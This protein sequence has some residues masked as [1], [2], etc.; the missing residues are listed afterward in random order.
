MIKK[1]NIVLGVIIMS[2]IFCNCKKTKVNN[3][4]L[5][6]TFDNERIEQDAD[7]VIDEN[8]ER[9]YFLCPDWIDYLENGYMDHLYSFEIFNSKDIVKS[10][11][12]YK[13]KGEDKK[14]FR[15]FVYE[16]GKITK[17]DHYPDTADDY[18]FIYEYD[19]YNRLIKRYEKNYNNET[20]EEWNY[21]YSY[22]KETKELI[23]K[24]ADTHD[25]LKIYTEKIQDGT[26]HLTKQ[27]KQ[28][29]D[30]FFLIFANGNLSKKRWVCSL[31]N[32]ERIFSYEREKTQMQAFSDGELCYWEDFVKNNDNSATWE[33]YYGNSLSEGRFHSK[34]EFTNFDKYDNWTLCIQENE[35]Y[36]RIFEYEE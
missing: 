17:D 28:D 4:P 5:N 31:F 26:Y 33:M 2:T 14:L 6:N 35:S 10:I 1:R 15:K 8:P 25:N 30:D 23:C 19:N 36:E 18:S 21:S 13:L 7:I 16:K 34:R 27:V 24:C 9:D 12:I 32:N 3:Q 11:E 22:D 29:I 20:V